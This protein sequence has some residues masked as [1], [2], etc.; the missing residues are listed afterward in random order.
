M[1]VIAAETTGR[2]TGGW[3]FV[4]AAYGITWATFILYAASLYVRQKNLEQ[5]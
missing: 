1:I 5:S 4:Y 3:E 2:I